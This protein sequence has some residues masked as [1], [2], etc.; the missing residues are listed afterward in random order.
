MDFLKSQYESNHLTFKNN[1][2]NK[3]CTNSLALQGVIIQWM[4]SCIPKEEEE[5]FIIII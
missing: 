2:G 4:D 3:G 5:G 1:I